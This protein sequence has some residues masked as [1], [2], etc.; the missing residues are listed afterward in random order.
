MKNGRFNRIFSIVVIVLAAAV[1]LT[2]WIIHAVAGDKTEA[3]GNTLTEKREL[4]EFPADYSNDW[5]SRLESYFSDHSPVRNK[6]IK[7]ESEVS[8]K[9]NAFYRNSISPVLTRMIVRNYDNASTPAPDTG[10]GPGP[11]APTVDLGILTGRT[12]VPAT[13]I[14]AETEAPVETATPAPTKEPA[15]EVPATDIPATDVPEETGT[16]APGTQ[17]PTEA[18]T[19][20]PA[21][22]GTPTPE[23][24]E[25]PTPEPT[26]HVHTYDKGK[27][28]QAA[29]CQ[30]EGRKVYTC[31]GCGATRT[32]TIPKVAHDMRV[33]M[34]ST[35]DMD[36]YGYTL[37]RCRVCGE[38]SLENVEAKI[39]NNTYLAPSYGGAAIFGKRDWLFYSGNDS[40]GYYRGTNLLDQATMNSWRLMFEQLDAACRAKGIDL[41]ILV[42]PNK[43]QMYPE[44][45]PN[46]Q[47]ENEKKRQD[48]MLEYMQNNSTVKYLYPKSE[49]ELTK[50]FYD[51]FYKQDTHWNS[52][53]GFTGTMAV[54]RALGLATTNVF[55]L[56]VKETTRTGGDLSNFSGYSTTY[57][58]WSVS[59][60]GNL[61]TTRQNYENHVT[62]SPTELSQ[63]FTPGALYADKKLVV[64]GDSFRH[65]MSTFMSKDFGK[66]T[67]AHRTELDYR[68]PVVMESLAELGEG[69]VLVLMCVERLDNSLYHAA[70]LLVNY[71]RG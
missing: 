70:E 37:K 42:A 7:L 65:A 2:P 28:E 68:T 38:Y 12:P 6:I 23:P 55:E 9:Y 50:I 18:V 14:P 5:F 3:D 63:F 8:G 29:S 10:E 56:N 48:V 33:V 35:A 32:E 67:F 60:K 1:V 58:E 53:G 21:P 27:V 15:T 39:V 66:S 49:L 61:E 64:I 41:V 45:M 20:T 69:D 46:Y 44:Y 30:R 19:A 52:L 54:Y 4:A 16:P 34:S 40:E 51:V 24:T 43:E 59:Y 17:G 13:E 22:T 62:S 11:A 71:L 47:I 36:N 57:R 26:P 31:T 25:P